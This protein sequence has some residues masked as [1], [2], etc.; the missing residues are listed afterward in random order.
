MVRGGDFRRGIC[1]GDKAEVISGEH[2]FCEVGP[3]LQGA[4]GRV[5][6]VRAQLSETERECGNLVTQKNLFE[7][8]LLQG[9]AGI[10]R[11]STKV[12]VDIDEAEMQKRLRETLSLWDMMSGPCKDFGV[13]A[14]EGDQFRAKFWRNGGADPDLPIRDVVMKG[15]Q[16]QVLH[17]FGLWCDGLLPGSSGGSVPAWGGAGAWVTARASLLCWRL[18]DLTAEA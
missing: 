2:R 9:M 12:A 18:V 15:N 13:E 14:E 6:W 7:S 11:G 4:R 17:R 8:G 1:G 3:Y 10:I 5:E 16:F